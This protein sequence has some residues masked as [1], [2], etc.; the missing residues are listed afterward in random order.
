MPRVDLGG[1]PLRGVFLISPWVSFDYD[2]TSA[3][4][5]KDIDM[6]SAHGCKGASKQFLGSSEED[7][8]SVPLR[9]SSEWWRGVEAQRSLIT[10]GSYEIFASDIAAFAKKFQVHNPATEVFEAQHEIHDQGLID[11][12]LGYETPASEKYMQRWVI[13]LLR[14]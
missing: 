3:R 1:H 10:S 5:N 14:E 4:V 2:T 9:A 12:I 13:Q 8:Y 7:E 11:G 6:I